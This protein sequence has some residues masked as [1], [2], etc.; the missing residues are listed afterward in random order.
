MLEG[1][2]TMECVHKL[3][4]AGA[5]GEAIVQKAL[6]RHLPRTAKFR[7]NYL[8]PGGNEIDAIVLDPSIGVFCIEVK[9]MPIGGIC[10][11]TLQEINIAGR[12]NSDYNPVAQAWTGMFILQQ[13]MSDALGQEGLPWLIPTAAFPRIK[14]KEFED[15]FLTGTARDH[16][17]REHI[18]GLL[19]QDDL[20]DGEHLK[21]YLSHIYTNP[22]LG[23]GNNRTIDRR[24]VQKLAEALDASESVPDDPNPQFTST[25]GKPRKDSIQK[26]LEPGNRPD[27][28]INGLPGS[29][30]TQ[31]L[32]DIATNHAH[33]GRRV[34][35]ACYNKVL[36]T[37]LRTDLDRL[38]LS[39]RAH[40]RIII[41]D[42]YDLHKTLSRK[43][44]SMYGQ[45]D[46]F[47]ETV[48]VDEAQD[49]YMKGSKYPTPDLLDL[50][51]PYVSQEAEWFFACGR[52]Q[53]LY[54]TKPKRVAEAEK[55]TENVTSLRR[56]GR[57]PHT[58]GFRESNFSQ[59]AFD[60]QF[61]PSKTGK[62]GKEMLER[63]KAIDDLSNSLIQHA[64]EQL[65]IR[66]INTKNSAEPAVEQYKH[67]IQQELETL[68]KLGRE[69]DLMILAPR[70]DYRKN[71]Q[72][73]DHELAPEVSSENCSV[74]EALKELGVDFLDQV[75]PDNRRSR[76]AKNQVRFVTVHSSRGL[77]ATRVLLI[78]PHELDFND[79]QKTNTAAYIALS[80][81]LN[82]TTVLTVKDKEPSRF[83]SFVEKA[84]RAYVEAV[85]DYKCSV[86]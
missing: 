72:S 22:P 57:R 41:V 85:N 32:L 7:F 35:F 11:Y 86:S 19:F 61:N 82:G 81:A 83:Q 68:K 65:T 47:F 79:T 45:F 43:N 20:D 78:A 15:K 16:D 53:E 23:R 70:K 67:H 3:A 1:T 80:R 39:R 18:N 50:L 74:R 62:F 13:R 64:T 66:E 31:A 30:K 42:I 37:K 38:E 71:E 46:Q 4:P 28:V 36:A 55:I 77:Q 63:I 69:N 56:P 54:G 12:K 60:Y 14:R 17:L 25:L 2:L 6:K 48:C 26:Y 9:G 5:T 21:Q 40:N 44:S 75:N 10:N 52:D 58:H 51:T 59:L 49:L 34:L 84:N 27:T 33:R 76:L 73:N 29:G 8:A 24:T